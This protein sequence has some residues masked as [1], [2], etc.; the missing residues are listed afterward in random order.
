[1]T[2]PSGSR[3]RTRTGCRA[4][5]S[6]P[7]QMLACDVWSSGS[8]C[9]LDSPT[10]GKSRPAALRRGRL[11]FAGRAPEATIAVR[12]ADENRRCFPRR[13]DGTVRAAAWRR[14]QDSPPP[15]AA[16]LRAG[17]EH[18]RNC[19]GR[20]DRSISPA[21]RPYGQV[22][23]AV[24]SALHLGSHRGR[25]TRAGTIGYALAYGLCAT[26]AFEGVISY[27]VGSRCSDPP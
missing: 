24:R 18:R 27:M 3:Q 8:A 22:V 19:G 23:A 1:V 21:P 17:V 25:G 26:A 13:V 9:T 4:V 7:Y 11:P 15:A 2:T 10:R 12:S 5:R 14:S 16:P 20:N 6:K